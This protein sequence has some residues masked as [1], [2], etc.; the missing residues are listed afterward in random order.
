MRTVLSASAH[1]K[2]LL[3]GE[4]AAVYGHPAVGLGLPF[5]LHANIVLHRDPAGR[6]GPD[7]SQAT[8]LVLA[9]MSDEDA[10]RLRAALRLAAEVEPSLSRVA[11]S[12][13]VSSEIP[14]GA[15]LGSSAALCAAISRAL[16]APGKKSARPE[17]RV[18]LLAHAMEHAY[19][20]TP[21]GIDTGLALFDGL[22]LLRAGTGSLPEPTAL[23]GGRFAL[24]AGC[25]PR[26]GNTGTLV[27]ALRRRVAARDAAA[28][29]AV[30]RLGAIAEE[31]A[32]LFCAGA[33]PVA[34]PLAR[35]AGSAQKLLAGI[36]L[37]SDALEKAID[38]GVRSGGLGG[39]LS[40]AGGGGA[41]FVVFDSPE[42]A[43]AALPTIAENCNSDSAGQGV[44][45]FALEW[46]GT[47]VKLLGKYR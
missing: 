25:L 8:G 12:L 42:A 2:L 26:A 16:L 27:G 4:H 9:G 29:D 22:A 17:K 18:H 36:G 33:G 13:S 31:S 38:A 3:F 44:P 19:H 21:S 35:L 14:R 5:V 6:A 40:G 1:G 37:S 47:A 30:D 34:G 28:L 43:T 15:G 11:G 46:D 24:A 23:E 45:L 10:D 39:K 20:G 32:E 7:T 41:F